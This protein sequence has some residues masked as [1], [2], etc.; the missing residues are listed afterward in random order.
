[1]TRLAPAA[2]ELRIVAAATL[3][4]GGVRAA[5]LEGADRGDLRATGLGLGACLL[6][7][8]CLW[9]ARALR[10]AIRLAL[11]M[12]PR[13]GRERTVVTLVRLAA[14]HRV[15]DAPAMAAGGL[16]GVGLAAL[17]A[18]ARVRRAE[19]ILGRR[20]LRE[21]RRGAPIRRSSLVLAPG[22]TAGRAALPPATPWP[23]HRPPPRPPRSAIE[24]E[25]A[26]PAARHTP[27][28]RTPRTGPVS[29]PGAAP[30]Q[31][32]RS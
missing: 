15:E 3:A 13:Q 16:L 26:N 27:G 20:L 12:L 28:V 18:A 8:W 10:L 21:P 30:R 29:P 19:R 14:A 5:V 4:V 31:R 22:A 7:V 11:P 1:M 17:L 2:L 25:P 23:A 9:A 24:L 32:R 6:A